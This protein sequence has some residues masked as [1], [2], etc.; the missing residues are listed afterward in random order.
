[1]A[2]SPVITFINHHNLNVIALD[3]RSTV[4]ALESS[5]LGTDIS[6]AA[7]SAYETQKVHCSE[8]YIR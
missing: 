8:M 1:M 5:I 2:R 3:L 6:V 4:P 7:R